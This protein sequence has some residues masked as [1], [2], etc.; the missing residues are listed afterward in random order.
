ML[1][2][3]V[4]QRPPLKLKTLMVGPLGGV[5]S[6]CPGAPTIN[7]KKRQHQAPRRCR[8]WSSGSAHHQL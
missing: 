5:G 7:A 8:S 4:R 1:A 2:A 3:G 6:R